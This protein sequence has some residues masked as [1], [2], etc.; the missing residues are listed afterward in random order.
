MPPIDPDA[1]FAELEKLGEDEVRKRLA[2]RA[3]YGGDTAPLV[4]EWIRRKDQECNALS[5]REQIRIA[6]SAKNAAWI[7][8]IAAIIAAISAIIV[9]VS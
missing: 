2:S 8:A 6:R 5:N 4:T 7:A 3:I 9:L 1:F